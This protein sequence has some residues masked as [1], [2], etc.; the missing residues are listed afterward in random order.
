MEAPDRLIFGSTPDGGSIGRNRR[1]AA[2]WGLA[3]AAVRRSATAEACRPYGRRARTEPQPSGLFQVAIVG[4]VFLLRLSFGID[5]RNAAGLEPT[6]D[7]RYVGGEE[8]APAA[9]HGGHIA[10]EHCLGGRLRG[11]GC[12]IGAVQIIIEA[13]DPAVDHSK[14]EFG[15]LSVDRTPSCV[16]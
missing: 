10:I 14:G 1:A 15:R 8:R 7:G 16:K 5:F 13:M 3:S 4:I 2:P 12:G 9:H 6:V 11:G